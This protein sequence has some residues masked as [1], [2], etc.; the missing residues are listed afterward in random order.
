MSYHMTKSIIRLITS[1]ENLE[2]TIFIINYSVFMI[3]RHI[4]I[5]IDM[6]ILAI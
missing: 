5:P 3:N 4:I 2:I 1:D 6:A